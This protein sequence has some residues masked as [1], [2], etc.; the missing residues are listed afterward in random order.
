M[1]PQEFFGL[2]EEEC[3]SDN[4]TC[5]YDLCFV[6]VRGIIEYGDGGYV[7]ISSKYE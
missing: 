1:K 4:N 3:S 6:I 7:V 5:F 2:Y